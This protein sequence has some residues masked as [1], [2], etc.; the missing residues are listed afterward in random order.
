MVESAHY[1]SMLFQLK[2]IMSFTDFTI[3]TFPDYS[4]QDKE[5]YTL[6]DSHHDGTTKSLSYQLAQ[7]TKRVRNHR[8]AFFTHV[9]SVCKKNYSCCVGCMSSLRYTCSTNDE[10]SNRGDSNNAFAE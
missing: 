1:G 5:T 6:Y 3:V 4:D 7:D 2:D 10:A 9:P 8:V